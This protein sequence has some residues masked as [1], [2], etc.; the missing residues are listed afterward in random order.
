VSFLEVDFCTKKGRLR[1]RDRFKLT[2]ALNF[3]TE[4]K[5]GRTESGQVFALR[6]DAVSVARQCG[7]VPDF[8]VLDQ[9]SAGIARHALFL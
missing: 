6:S 7:S 2:E 9:F 1:A 8:H 5:N 4:P 3:A